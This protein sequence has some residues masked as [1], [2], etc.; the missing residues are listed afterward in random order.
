MNIM[1]LI[2]LIAAAL[3][4][5]YGISDGGDINNFI[6]PGAA[7][8]TLGGTFAALMLTFP[9]RTF[10]SMP[11]LLLRVFFPRTFNFDPRRYITDI[12]EITVSAKKYGML[13]FEE[14]IPEYKDK[15][16]Q[17]AIQLAVDS[18]DAETIR[19]VM[20]TELG[21]MVERHK[22]GIQ[23]FEKGAVYAPGFGMLGT[24]SGLVNMLA[25][26]EDP[27][28]ITKSMA[29]ALIATFYG[30]IIAN[31]IFLPLSVRLQKRSD[32]EALCKQLVI[33]GIAA[34]VNGEGPKQIQERLISYVPPA[35]RMPYITKK[36]RK[37]KIQRDRIEN[38][39]ES[40][41]ESKTESITK[42]KEI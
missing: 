31:V 3:L 23:F 39:I 24:L 14:K 13:Y 16:L 1:S 25:Q 21:C 5:I 6:S 32:E 40:M 41:I 33:E 30:L 37:V 15:F 29:A 12:E 18:E 35:M 22:T 17:K 8:V 9:L 11:K 27:A 2:G 36:A 19:E 42:E 4:M 26:A 38:K 10:A 28:G 34:V 7:A 20:E